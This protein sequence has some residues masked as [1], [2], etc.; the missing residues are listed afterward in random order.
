MMANLS[1]RLH[2]SRDEKMLGGVCG[3]LG[4]HF[5]IDPT[6]VRLLFVLTALYTGIGLFAYLALWILMPLEPAPAETPALP[7]AGHS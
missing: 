3:G 7:A 4:E 1:K 5:G 2:R 6:V